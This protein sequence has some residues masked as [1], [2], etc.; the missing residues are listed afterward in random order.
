MIAGPLMVCLESPSRPLKIV[1]L[2]FSEAAENLTNRFVFL[3]FKCTRS[4][5]TI[6]SE[7]RVHLKIKNTK[8]L[9]KFSAASEKVKATIFKGRE[10]LSRQ[11]IRGPAIIEEYDS[12]IVVP[13]GWTAKVDSLGN[14]LITRIGAAA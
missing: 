2:T 4:S 11:T 1:A 12:T 5:E 10:G 13:P 7:E 14:L 6:V 8:R 9:V 3:I